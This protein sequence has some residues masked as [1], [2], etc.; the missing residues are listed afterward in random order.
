[1]NSYNQPQN[2]L[3]LL[4]AFE[5]IRELVN[6]LKPDTL[7]TYSELNQ[8]EIDNPVRPYRRRTFVRTSHALIEGVCYR[9]RMICSV[10]NHIPGHCLTAEELAYI[11]ETPKPDGTPNYLKG[12]DILKESF[13]YAAKVLSLDFQLNCNHQGWAVFKNSKK[14]RDH[15]AHPKRVVELDISEANVSNCHDG[16]K[17]FVEEFIRFEKS[18]AK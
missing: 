5:K 13:K 1:M 6:A 12:D 17:W 10:A 14:V 16:L 18:P 11:L 8:T 9:L 3:P 4:E 15:L 2:N 7:I